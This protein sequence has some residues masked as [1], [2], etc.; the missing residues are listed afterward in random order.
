[1]AHNSDCRSEESL[2]ATGTKAEYMDACFTEETYVLAK[3]W[4]GIEEIRSIGPGLEVLSRNEK[5]GEVAYRKVLRVIASGIRDCVEIRLSNGHVV[6]ATREHPFW[7]TDRGWVA[8][9]GLVIGDQLLTFNGEQ[10]SV[11]SVSDWGLEV[12]YNLE[13]EE[14]NTFFVTAAGVWVHNCNGTNA[15][16]TVM[17]TR[18]RL[19]C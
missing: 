8:A 1:M 3:T 14:F 13:V 6:E 5:T 19:N 15:K 9:S 7:V 2:A 16:A 11:K 12:V 17:A 18:I 10:C 4:N